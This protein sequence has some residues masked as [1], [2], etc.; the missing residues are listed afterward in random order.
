MSRINSLGILSILFAFIGLAQDSTSIAGK[1]SDASSAP[2]PGVVLVIH[3]VEN[4]SER[5]VTSDSEGRYD[6]PGLAVGSYAIDASKEGFATI[7]RTGITL[8]AGQH[9]QINLVLQV[10][11]M[12]Q[13]ITV[14]EQAPI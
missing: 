13:Q 7:S 2:L 11:E 5:S 12:R 8:V 4:G 10:G 1:V 9:A 6:V 14:E 3:N